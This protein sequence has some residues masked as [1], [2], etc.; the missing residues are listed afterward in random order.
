MASN[1]IQKSFTDVED[2]QAGYYHIVWLDE[3]VN[4]F[5]NQR[6]LKK[7][8]EIDRTIKSFT[9]T[10]EFI[11]YI[12][13]QDAKQTMVYII[14]IVSGALSK[15]IP[16]IEKYK[17][18]LAI[19]IF[20]TNIDDYEHLKYD[21]LRAICTDANELI[22]CM[23][24]L[25]ARNNRTIDFSIMPDQSSTNSN[26]IPSK[27]QYPIRNLTDDQASFLWFNQM[28]KFMITL[29]NDDETKA[30]AEM[31][32]YSR[33]HYKEHSGMLNKI[34][35]FNNQSL[36][37]DQ[38]NAIFCYTDNSFIYECT[39][40][41]LR[42]E[43]ISQVYSCRYIIKLLCRQLKEQHEQF[44]NE[45]NRKSK[46]K[47]LLRLY[48][49]QSL[50]LEYIHFLRTNINSL[51]S[52][53]GFVSTTKDKDVAMN[54][55]RLHKQKDL[56]PVLMKIDIDMTSEHSVAFADISNISK[57][58]EEH[59]VLFSIGPI[60]RVKSVQFDDKQQI[61]IIHL[62]LSQHDQLTVIKYIEQ[63]YANNVNSDDLSIL[64]GKLLFDMGK[65]ESAF[66][67]FSDALKRLS[68]NNNRIRATYLNNIGI[69]YNEMGDRNEA[70]KCYKKA[71]DIYEQT[72]NIRGIGACQ[73]N[74]A[75]IY[76]V[77]RDY[78]KASGLA[79]KALNIRQNSV[80]QASTHDLLGCIYL[81]SFNTD[82][83]KDHFE[84]ALILRL[85]S[86]KEIN[87]YHPDI[88]V[89]YHNLGK[90][91]EKQFKYNEAKENYSRAAEI[92]RHNFPQTHPWIIQIKEC[93]ERIR[94]Q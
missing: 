87:P 77:R 64:F 94:K 14:F 50:K 90:V 30:K 33:K 35:E 34:N 41:V 36:I 47:S 85:R 44:I 92:Y 45:Y 48:R 78:N 11:A 51:I 82:A 25:I 80:E 28:H 46:K 73:H 58:S 20:C 88:G 62:S 23:E 91:N 93:L 42:K 79:L 4:N 40:T 53:N 69:C 27:D 89:S 12:R 86:L 39:N 84:Q 49:G 71:L 32:E 65:C 66:T 15:V 60:F 13:Q 59:E 68:D 55:I 56:E 74:I 10:E 16:T 38:Q 75:S 5:Y 7:F 54:F 26:S 2:D 52:L 24:L 63:T 3:H 72:N 76:Y 83:A 17:C 57:F 67:Y 43:N 81:T 19:F 8:G 29:E 61:Y 70:L 22:N 31:I 6:K 21:K 18:I 9:N 37:E 1:T